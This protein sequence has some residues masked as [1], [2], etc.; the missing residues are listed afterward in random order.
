[1]TWTL[2]PLWLACV[3]MV[4]SHAL[5]EV[6]RKIDTGNFAMTYL[7][8]EVFSAMQLDCDSRMNL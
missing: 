3:I 5:Q 1:M 8:S 4:T 6:F 7:D 2:L